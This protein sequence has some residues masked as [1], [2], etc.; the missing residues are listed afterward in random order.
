MAEF[1]HFGFIGDGIC[2]D[3]WGA[4]PYIISAAGHDFRFEDS[5]QYGPLIIEKNG[6]PA[7]VQ[8]GE[9]SPFWARHKTWVENGRKTAGDGVTCL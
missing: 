8:P 5:D 3:V 4:G 2:I 1:G 9:R 6:E 7:V